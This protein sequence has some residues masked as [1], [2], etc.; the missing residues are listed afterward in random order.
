MPHSF[1]FDLTFAQLSILE[2]STLAQLVAV[3]LSIHKEWIIEI[4][5]S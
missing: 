4:K 1:I 5:L 2:F 3:G